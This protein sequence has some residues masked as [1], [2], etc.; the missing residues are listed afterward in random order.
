M[1]IQVILTFIAFLLICQLQAQKNP[2]VSLSAHEVEAKQSKFLYEKVENDPLDARIYTLDNGLK[3]YMT[4]YRNAPRIQTYVAVK[5]GSKHDPAETTGLAHYFE[6]MMFKGTRNFGTINYEEEAKY[7][8]QIDS[9]FEVYRLMDDDKERRQLYRVIDSISFIASKY[10]IPNEYDKL[11]STIGSTNTNAYTSLEQTV[12]MEDIPSN[13]LENWAI[14]QADRFVNPV[15]RLFHTELETIYEEKNMTMTNDNMK[16]YF[17]LLEG[18]FPTHPYGTQT[19]IGTQEHL[20]NPSMKNIREFHANYYVPNNMAIC[21]SGDFDPDEA[22]R[23][24]DKHF[25]QWKPV[26]VPTFTYKK[27]PPIEKPVVKEVLGPDAAMI[28]LGFRF[29]GANSYDAN[30]LSIIDMI[31]MNSAAGLFDINLLQGQKLLE[32]Y[33]YNSIMEDYSALVLIG[34]PKS[35]QSLDEV[36]DLL[37]SQ[38]DLIKKGE[39]DDWLIDAIIND[40]KLKQIKQFEE[41]DSRARAFVD[42]FVL[43]VPWEDYIQSI[44][45]LEEITKQ[46]VIDF[47]NKYFSDNY[48][49][50]YKQTG[51]DPNLQRIAKNRVTPIHIN[52]DDESE[53]LKIIKDNQPPEIEPHFLDFERDIHRFTV[54]NIPV[55]YIRNDENETFS[56]F[57]VFDMGTQHNPKLGT[58]IDYLEFIGTDKFSAE[59]IK[60]EFYKLG[61]TYRVSSSGDQVYVSLRGLSENMEKGM[62]LFEHLLQNCEPNQEA[63][64][65]YV[66]NTMQKRID[67]KKNIQYIFSY[68]VMYGIYGKDHPGTWDL[69]EKELKSQ[70]PKELTDIIKGLTSYKHEVLYYGNMKEAELTHL[71]QRYHRVPESLKDY[72]PK[73]EIIQLPT[74]RNQVFFVDFDTPHTQIL[75]VS[76]GDKGFDKKNTA[77]IQL[78]NEYFGTSMNS[79]VFQE[80]REARGLAYAAMSI[81]QEPAEFDKY[82]TGISYIATQFDKVDEAITGFYELLNNMPESEKSFQ[83]AKESMIQSMRSDRIT[84]S[85]IFFAYKRAQK[86]GLKDDIRRTTFEVVQNLRFDDLRKFHN[87]NLKDKTHTILVVGNKDDLSMKDLKKYGKLKKLKMKDIFGY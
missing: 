7:I 14:I 24:I 27:S 63:W 9:L 11:M 2:D 78:F 87:S 21:L 48:V 66:E 8:A 57:Y 37:L 62:K 46:D 54:G 39:F 31:L 68:L 16:A 84:R 43:G 20:K 1:K 73:R 60:K 55:Q 40:L 69:S 67:A 76:R 26:E 58:A 45:K 18:L 61:C 25:G 47:V 65:K 22:I 23:I 79:I 44:S 6:H 72:P 15:L 29:E 53:F 33:S 10:A 59:D 35:G 32:A 74:D 50:V 71:L 82:Y 17:T 30:M 56:L 3:V 49:A 52:R 28:Y 70:D 5:A 38:L 83:L 80:M 75:M 12:Y 36:R 77:V 13:Q 4:V 41:N 51:R 19:V 42:A 64:D 34:K 81:Y 86:L 85:D